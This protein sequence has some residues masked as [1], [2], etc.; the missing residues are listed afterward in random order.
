MN[1][2]IKLNGLEELKSGDDINH[3]CAILALI[4]AFVLE[5]SKLAGE[6]GGGSLNAPQVKRN[7]K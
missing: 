4:A 3:L 6:G 5:S 1:C 7:K 2:H